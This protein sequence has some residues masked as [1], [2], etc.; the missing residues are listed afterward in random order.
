MG[1]FNCIFPHYD[2]EK[3]E[4]AQWIVNH[5]NHKYLGIYPLE[6]YSVEG[7]CRDYDVQELARIKAEIQGVHQSYEYH[8]AHPKPKIGDTYKVYLCGKCVD[9][10]WN[11]TNVSH[12]ENGVFFTITLEDGTTKLKPFFGSGSIN[13][14]KV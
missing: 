12:N 10:L 4:L 2:K 3:E 1:I 14:T 6:E 8:K 7:C 9:T 11:V 13:W 5:N